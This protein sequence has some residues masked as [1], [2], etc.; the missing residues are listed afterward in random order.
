[1]NRAERRAI[2]FGH[3]FNKS[4]HWYQQC[5]GYEA[6]HICGIHQEGELAWSEYCRVTRCTERDPLWQ[7]II[8]Y[9]LED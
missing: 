3:P 1:M 2:Q 7:G 6:I 8:E 5:Y 4:R 9:Q